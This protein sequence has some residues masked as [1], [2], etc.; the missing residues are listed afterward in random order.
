MEFAFSLNMLLLQLSDGD[1]RLLEHKYDFIQ[2]TLIPP[3][4]NLSYGFLYPEAFVSKMI[5]N[6]TK[7]CVDFVFE[8]GA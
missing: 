4:V 5:W 8:F 1:Q 7:H 2:Y 3:I 6:G